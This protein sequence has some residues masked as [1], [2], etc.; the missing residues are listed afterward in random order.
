VLVAVLLAVLLGIAALVVDL[1]LAMD[2]R[3]QA[4]NAADS[5]ALAAAVALADGE[6][7]ATAIARAMSYA[8]RN[9][10]VTAAEWAA[11]TDDH[12]LPVHPTTPCIS[13]DGTTTRV[14]VPERRVPAL[15]SGVLGGE[16]IRVRAAAEAGWTERGEFTGPCV[17]CV[18][19]EFAGQ[20]GTLAVNGGS[21]WVNGT[22]HFNNNNNGEVTVT[23]GDIRLA[24]DWDGVGTFTPAPDADVDPFTD[25]F[26]ALPLPPSELDRGQPATVGS[27]DCT[28]GNYTSIADCTSLA[29]GLYVLAGGSHAIHGGVD[30]EGVTLYFTCSRRSG[31]RTYPDDCD[32]DG[33]DG[34]T[35]AGAGIGTATLSAPDSGPYQGF[36]VIL[37]RHNTVDLRWTGNGAL[38]V[39]GT[40][41]AP[42]ATLDL[43]GNGI[44]T[45]HGVTVVGD[46][47]LRGNHDHVYNGPQPGDP[48]PPEVWEL[49]T[50]IT[51]VN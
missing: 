18:L 9:Y 14:V 50:Q 13:L 47:D 40:L 44:Y 49:R 32:A 41:Y 4:Q 38:T 1:G 15:F 19:D 33:E 22:T 24:G 35:L 16:G 8:D 5:S 51:L 48:V 30:A 27:G 42:A 17:F 39:R 28:P 20:T 37:D 6:D 23:G 12:P 26:A 31:G 36:A 45:S 2:T 3:G 10:G 21:V 29:A 46:V 25:P 7:A 43:R 11:C 34:A